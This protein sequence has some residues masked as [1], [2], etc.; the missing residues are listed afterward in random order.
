[1][2]RGRSWTAE[3][4]DWLK[5]NWQLPDTQMRESL[6]RSIGTIRTKRRE[7]GLVGKE[8]ERKTDW[9]D[10]EIEH[11]GCLRL[12]QIQN[13]G[14][15][16]LMNIALTINADTPE[17]LTAAVKGMASQ[18]Q[19]C[20]PVSSPVVPMQSPTPAPV[21]TPANTMPQFVPSGSVV[22]AHAPIQ[23][24][25]AGQMAPEPPMT[26]TP[27]PAVPLAATPTYSLDQIAKAGAELAQAGKMNELLALLQ[28]FGIQAVTQLK[29]E[30][31]GPFA[32]ALRGLGAQL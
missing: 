30:Q 27:S 32:T 24:P 11:R 18:Y 25:P 23:M 16:E 20:T 6:N 5:E 4:L 13:T 8:N 9:S 22:P 12:L 31:I 15:R 3:D 26:P 2:G 14:G 17:E 28:Q 1:M 19:P 7:L 21:V 29:P 10:E